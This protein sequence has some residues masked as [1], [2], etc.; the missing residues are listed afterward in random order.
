MIKYVNT[1]FYVITGGWRKAPGSFIFSLTNKENL[2]PFKAPLKNEDVG[3]AITGRAD[4]GPIFGDGWD[5]AISDNAASNIN[6]HTDFGYTYQVP[7]GVSDRLTI[8]AGR[9]FFSPSE[10]EVLYLVQ[11]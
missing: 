6:S 3:G 9:R 11:N 1:I 8:L 2:P 5:L 7:S 4:R 10:V